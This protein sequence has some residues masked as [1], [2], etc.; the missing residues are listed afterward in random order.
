MA[1][2]YGPTPA[3]HSKNYHKEALRTVYRRRLD[4]LGL[5]LQQLELV[6]DGENTE[7]EARYLAMRQALAVIE[8]QPDG[9][10]GG[11][12]EWQH[13]HRRDTKQLLQ[14]V[15]HLRAAL[16][17]ML[18]QMGQLLPAEDVSR[19]QQE[20]NLDSRLFSQ[21]SKPGVTEQDL[22]TM[23]LASVG[24]EVVN[25]KAENAALKKRQ[26][27]SE[28]E[29]AEQRRRS[30]ALERELRELK[31]QMA[32]KEIQAASPEFSLEA[33]SRGKPQKTKDLSLFPRTFSKQMEESY[34]SRRPSR[35]NVVDMKLTSSPPS[36]FEKTAKADLLVNEISSLHEE[37]RH[38]RRRVETA[39]LNGSQEAQEVSAALEGARG[40]FL[41][42]QLRRDRLR[43]LVKGLEGHNPPQ[44][45]QVEVSLQERER[46]L[47]TRVEALRKDTGNLEERRQNFIKELEDCR[48][49]A[50]QRTAELRHSEELGSEAVARCAALQLELKL[51]QE[52]IFGVETERQELW[53]KQRRMGE[54]FE[55]AWEAATAEVLR[56]DKIVTAV[57]IGFK[58]LDLGSGT[59]AFAEAAFA[60]PGSVAALAYMKARRP[61]L[62]IVLL[63][64]LINT[65]MFSA[66]QGAPA[67]R[68]GPII[69]EEA[70]SFPFDCE[71]PF[72]FAVY[73]LDHY[74]PGKPDMTPN[75][76]LKGHR[77]GADFGHPSG[78]NMYHGEEIP[79]FPKHPHRG[80]ETITVT[81]RGWVDHTD[82]LGN[83]G[84][85]GGGDVQWM[86][87]GAGISHA[88]MFPL[89]NQDSENVLELFQIWINLPKRSKMVEPSFKMLWAEDLA[90]VHQ[91][92]GTEIAL[93]AGSLPGFGSPPAPP[94]NS[95]ASDPASDV[96]VLTL[97]I[98]A[99]GSWTLPAYA[100]AGVS[101][102]NRNAYIH[103]G[104]KS[105]I[106]GQVIH[107]QKRLK[108]R[109]DADTEIA[110]EDGPIEV[111]VLQGRDI[112]EPVVQHGPFV[113]NSREDISKAFRDYQT[114][115][116]GGWP[117][118]S[119]ALAHGPE[120]PRFAKYASGE[121]AKLA[122]MAA[123]LQRQRELLSVTP[124][125]VKEAL[126]LTSP[127]EMPERFSGGVWQQRLLQ[128]SLR[129]EQAELRLLEA[130]TDGVEARERGL[131]DS[132]KVALSKL[133]DLKQQ[134]E[135]ERIAKAEAQKIWAAAQ[136]EQQSLALQ[137]LRSHME[138]LRSWN[139]QRR[140]RL[141]KL[142]KRSTQ[143]PDGST[144][145]LRAELDGHLRWIFGT[146]ALSFAEK[147]TPE[148][149]AFDLHCWHQ[150][151]RGLRQ[152][153]QQAKASEAVEDYAEKGLE[154]S[155]WEAEKMWEEVL[156]LVQR[157]RTPSA[158]AAAE[159]AA[160]DA[161]SVEEI[162][163][164]S[165][166][167]EK[168][169]AA[170]AAQDTLRERL[171]EHACQDESAEP[172]EMERELLLEE[173]Q[174][175]AREEEDRH[176]ELELALLV[177]RREDAELEAQ[178]AGRAAEKAAE[179]VM[180]WRS[181]NFRELCR[182]ICQEM[183]QSLLVQLQHLCESAAEHPDIFQKQMEEIRELKQAHSAVS[184]A[185]AE[186]LG[187][188]DLLEAELQAAWVGTVAA[189]EEVQASSKELAMERDR[190]RLALDALRARTDAVE[191][192]AALA[193]MCEEL[194][195]EVPSEF[196][197]PKPVCL[198]LPEAALSESEGP[199]AC[200]WEES[201]S[202]ELS[203]DL[204]E[205]FVRFMEQMRAT[206][207]EILRGVRASRAL[208][209]G[210]RR[211]IRGDLEKLYALSEAT[212]QF[213]EFWSHSW[214]T[215][216]LTKFSNV[217]L[218]NHGLPAFVVG[219]LCAASVGSLCVL[220]L[221]PPWNL[222]GTV[223]GV[224]S[225]YVT[226]L[227]WS[228]RKQVFL[229]IACICQTDANLKA[230]GL[231]SI[232]AFLKNSRSFLVLWDEMA[233]FL[234]S[235]E[236]GAKKN[237]VVC[238]VF[239]APALLIGHL[240]LSVLLVAYLL[241]QVPI[242]PWGG[243]VMCLLTAPCLML[244]AVA[245]VAH[246]RSIEQIQDQVRGFTID[247]SSC[248][249]CSCGHVDPRTC[250]T[251]ICDR[252]LIVRCISLWFGSA[253]AFEEIV[254]T[255]LL[256]VLVH[257]L[258]TQ[259]FSYWRIVQAA[260]PALWMMIDIWCADSM[261]GAATE[262][263]VEVALAAVTLCFM[264]LPSV[265][266]LL[267][268]LAYKARHLRAPQTLIAAGLVAI[269]AGTFGFFLASERMLVLITGDQVI[270]GIILFW[271]MGAMTLWLWRCVP[272]L[273][274]DGTLSAEDF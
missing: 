39:D 215:G 22:A 153:L 92:D 128:E 210:P 147:R 12:A 117:W 248:H 254:R 258:K 185:Q 109:P 120:R 146:L 16:Q 41:E 231:L 124:E 227:L 97:K 135:G 193:A 244:F 178:A 255:R 91:A 168:A 13:R 273:G 111:L 62:C 243:L 82:S 61:I 226:L 74:P 195:L 155:L 247:K 176:R 156:S 85:F 1:Y 163:K 228:R 250:E 48:R 238:P 272:M 79:G 17:R 67:P 116:F 174:E 107:G 114:T 36:D 19:L 167:A 21:I 110:A 77:M 80:F 115:E 234:H 242:F 208:R 203:A 57:A 214:S 55:S 270:A 20:L 81:R 202:S 181:Q 191:F 262:D 68:G 138:A 42:S 219:T 251:M 184:A 38:L 141:L 209:S 98:P 28:A 148:K 4:H 83:A 118:K 76:S 130:S 90:T 24:K 3:Y 86:T 144:G 71:S 102:L 30:A 49:Q 121:E 187:S 224:L 183:T 70:M 173:A 11:C 223:T 161:A 113:G 241:S 162:V 104:T 66:C 25:L 73:H 194:V 198:G 265:C 192:S 93:I 201:E 264:F 101:G 132:L 142:A 212:D 274:H 50:A 261:K 229:D 237:L 177:A 216:A 5:K 134:L 52:K 140:G 87:A 47:E 175:E 131:Q 197:E 188:A 58:F 268:N 249:C 200:S 126:A 169:A 196:P 99:K 160:L 149:A 253:E 145:V 240:G 143:Q 139:S 112:G 123:E 259:V 151:L 164:A 129:A 190:C 10:C 199:E 235:R 60:L 59:S 27:D 7:R 26:A 133:E 218:L 257:Q 53:Q 152:A 233:A 23:K 137:K 89:L 246:Y 84:R 172:A 157:G 165:V 213:E 179:A 63:G 252:K 204:Y 105:K 88:E 106:G 96:M 46:E 186:A 14:E 40:R 136:R 8:A 230:Q 108:L 158:A 9:L 33:R 35:P 180:T 205:Q 211:W 159:G 103:T 75:A 69:R 2:G 189:I 245:V 217:L 51:L 119:S 94:P 263:L 29:L 100:G 267:L 31:Q 56:V 222:W 170:R 6:G 15:A 65:T 269:G 271:V 54:Q 260:S 236:P 154:V 182:K 171:G 64:C 127:E 122:A 206:S 34:L 125:P 266:L 150:A 232:G 78:W 43:R 207:P 256:T 220:R 45:E 72:L 95:Y 32:Q 44:P 37:R 166:E 18:A 239:V 225:Y 221:L